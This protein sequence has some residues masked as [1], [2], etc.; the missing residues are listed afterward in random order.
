M[1]N[2]KVLVVLQNNHPWI[3][4]EHGIYGCCVNG[5]RNNFF[6]IFHFLLDKGRTI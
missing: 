4:I 3:F 2:T 5:F 6:N 1:I